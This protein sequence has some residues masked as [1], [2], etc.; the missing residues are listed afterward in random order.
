MKIETSIFFC[1]RVFPPDESASNTGSMLQLTGNLSGRANVWSFHNTDYS[2]VI[3]AWH[4]RE[5][6]TPRPDKGENAQDEYGSIRAGATRSGNDRRSAAQRVSGCL[7]RG[8]RC[9][10]LP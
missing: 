8:A 9:V 7:R 4:A 1:N 6:K 5:R 10:R 3:I 2:C